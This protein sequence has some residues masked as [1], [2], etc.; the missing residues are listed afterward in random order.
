MDLAFS[1]STMGFRANKPL[2]KCILIDSQTIDSNVM[3]LLRNV[4][5]QN[6]VEYFA[7]NHVEYIFK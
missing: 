3:S 2:T 4:V 7:A 5:I 6:H 1:Y